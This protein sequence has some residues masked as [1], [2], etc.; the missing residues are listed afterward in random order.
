MN[1]PKTAVKAMY[2]H[3]D[4]VSVNRLLY[5]INSKKSAEK[6]RRKEPNCMAVNPSKPFLIRIKELP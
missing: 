6:I 2:F 4:L 3:C 1:V 5:P